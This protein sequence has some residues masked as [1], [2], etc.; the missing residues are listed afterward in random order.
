MLGYE[1]KMTFFGIQIVYMV[2]KPEKLNQGSML[3][4]SGQAVVHLLLYC[5][6]KRRHGLV[7]FKIAYRTA[8]ISQG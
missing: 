4:M 5:M 7:F 6:R 2:T 1:H 8:E 3:T